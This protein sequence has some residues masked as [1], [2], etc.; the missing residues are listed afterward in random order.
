MFTAPARRE[1]L[2]RAVAVPHWGWFLMLTGVLVLTTLGVSFWWPYHREQDVIR[3]VEALGGRVEI[4]T[5]APRWL[6]KYLDRERCHFMKVFDRVWLVDLDGTSVDDSDLTCL[7]GLADPFGL[8]LRGTRIT[9]AGLE[10]LGR[11]PNVATL[12]LEGTAVS[13]VGME[14][15]SRLK[16]L[17][18]LSLDH[19]RV[20]ERGL[21]HVARLSTLIELSLNHTPTNDMGLRQL[22][23]MSELRLVEVRDTDVTDAGVAELKR[24]LPQVGI[25]R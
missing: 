24:A 5:D 16:N 2:P 23:G 4:S 17:M 22:A 18:M 12:F 3:R 9:D 7:S 19:T 8:S 1:F 6:R 15:V 20:T 11:M 21:V 25:S 10:Q 13:D 14:R